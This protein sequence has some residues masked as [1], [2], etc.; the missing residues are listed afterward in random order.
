MPVEKQNF[1]NYTYK[2]YCDWETDERFEL[3]DGIP[4]AMAAPLIRHQRALGKLSQKIANHLERTKGHSCEVFF[5]PF[6]VR[7]NHEKGDDTVV[8]PDLVVICDPKK[9]EDGKACKGAP[10]LV[11][12]I[13]SPSNPNHDRMIK[14]HKYIEAGV[15]EL[16][17]VDL[18][19]KT[20]EVYR[21]TGEDGNYLFTVYMS[22]ADIPVGILPGLFIDTEDILREG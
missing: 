9:I 4:Y 6:D 8:Q 7:L 10:D 14:F 17:F 18:D 13:L 19:A 22:G 21:R 12:E 16:W 20:V 11:I 1:S 5:A 3:I 2:D 15:G